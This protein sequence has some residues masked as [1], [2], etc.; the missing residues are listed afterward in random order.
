MA[1]I[2]DLIDE[3]HEGDSPLSLAEYLG[4]TDGQYSEWVEMGSVSNG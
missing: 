2:D 3:W 4:M 1:E